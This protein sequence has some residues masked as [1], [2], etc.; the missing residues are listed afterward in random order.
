MPMP[1]SAQDA[2]ES[3]EETP[4]EV[5]G[6]Q[7][8][9]S[10]ED[11]RKEEGTPDTKDGDLIYYN[12]QD[13]AGIQ[14]MLGFA[15]REDRGLYQITYSTTEQYQDKNHYLEDYRTINR[16]LKDKYGT[17]D[18]TQHR[19]D[20]VDGVDWETAFVIGDVRYVDRWQIQDGDIVLVHLLTKRNNTPLHMIIYEYKPISSEVTEDSEEEAKEKL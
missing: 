10:R 16:L 7:W 8:G 6:H 9:D 12:Q 1:L 20:R 19:A 4:F 15:F 18:T 13:L 5:R 2:G 14:M 17:P 3:E 11:I